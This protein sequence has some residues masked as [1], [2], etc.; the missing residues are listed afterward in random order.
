MLGLLTTARVTLVR[1]GLRPARARVSLRA[2][3]RRRRERFIEREYRRA[4]A[5]GHLPREFGTPFYK[6]VPR[7]YW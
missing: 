3:L 6:E 5:N 1:P 2:M 7:R 4:V